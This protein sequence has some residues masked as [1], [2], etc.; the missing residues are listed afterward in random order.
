MPGSRWS[1]QPHPERPAPSTEE[2]QVEWA[3]ATHPPVL[4]AYPDAAICEVGPWGTERS[5][6]AETNTVADL[7]LFPDAPERHFRHL[8]DADPEP[9]QLPD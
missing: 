9:R 7:R 8:F 4:L 5:S 3:L 6:R 1:E 2:L